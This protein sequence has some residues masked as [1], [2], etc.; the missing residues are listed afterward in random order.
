MYADERVNARREAARRDRR[1]QE[2]TP[3]GARSGLSLGADFIG[4]ARAGSQLGRQ[5]PGDAEV[6]S[7]VSVETCLGESF[8]KLSSSLFARASPADVCA[9][10][11]SEL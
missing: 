6:V 2:S 11:I 9:E 7:M 1:G 10:S 8:L 3:A 4:R 5:E